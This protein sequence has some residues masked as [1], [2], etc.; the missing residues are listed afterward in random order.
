MA[1][2]KFDPMFNT[3]VIPEDLDKRKALIACQTG[4]QALDNGDRMPNHFMSVLA[5]LGNTYKF[6]VTRDG[7]KKALAIST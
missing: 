4:W 6:S 7:I 1:D 3:G 5:E 2:A